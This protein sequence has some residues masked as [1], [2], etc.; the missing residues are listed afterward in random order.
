M[1]GRQSNNRVCIGLAR[2]ISL[3]LSH[4]LSAVLFES[5]D[6]TLWTETFVSDRGAGNYTDFVRTPVSITKVY[7]KFKCI[8]SSSSTCLGWLCRTSQ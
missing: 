7:I 8:S 4:E 5:E 1:L 6:V 2:D 3:F